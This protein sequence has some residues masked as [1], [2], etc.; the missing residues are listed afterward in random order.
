MNSF[1]TEIDRRR[2]MLRLILREARK[3]GERANLSRDKLY[4]DGNSYTFN[5]IV[6]IPFPTE[7]LAND[8]HIYFSSS[9]S[10]YSNFYSCKFT[11]GKVNYCNV[12]QKLIATEKS[13]L[14][15]PIR[16]T[17]TGQ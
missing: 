17:N 16:T 15:G 4:I 6:V 7:E 3:R 2:K 1:V 8:T 14:P 10:P 9:L 12:E 13:T 5:Y 11:A